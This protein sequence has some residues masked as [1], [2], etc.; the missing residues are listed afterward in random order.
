MKKFI[1]KYKIKL[2]V[3][4]KSNFMKV[5][6]F[7]QS[8][9]SNISYDMFMS[10]YTSTIDDT[11]YGTK[12]W[13]DRVQTNKCTVDDV[14]LLVHETEHVLSFRNGLWKRYV[15][16]G[17]RALREAECIAA[18]NQFRISACDAP[19]IKDRTDII[20]QLRLYGCK[21]KDCVAAA[22]YVEIAQ[23]GPPSDMVMDALSVFAEV[24]TCDT[25]SY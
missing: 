8:F 5:V 12:E 1:E 13:V 18:A 23:Q 16:S 10:E 20:N 11:I 25:K 4:N 22:N 17:G 2:V 14:A 6:G 24:N 7:A 19:H 3:K 15:L 21:F 9:F